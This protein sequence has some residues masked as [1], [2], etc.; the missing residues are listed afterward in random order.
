[1][2]TTTIQIS[3]MSCSGCVAKLTSVLGRLPGV[4]SADVSLD[5]GRA[6]VQFDPARASV[7]VFKQAIENAG[8]DLS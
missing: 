7:D 6:I 1:M 2:E 4:Q 8:Y 3:G 5:N